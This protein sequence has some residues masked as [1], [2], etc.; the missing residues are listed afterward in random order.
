MYLEGI[1][2]HVLIA[3]TLILCFPQLR[4][5]PFPNKE[6]PKRTVKSS[7]YSPGLLEKQEVRSREEFFAI[8]PGWRSYI[9]LTGIKLYWTWSF[10]MPSN[11]S[12]AEE[13]LVLCFCE[14]NE[15]KPTQWPHQMQLWSFLL[16]AVSCQALS[17][18][19]LLAQTTHAALKQPG[20]VLPPSPPQWGWAL[21]L[22][23]PGAQAEEWKKCHCREKSVFL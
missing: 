7:Y 21:P 14:L 22:T 6:F 12:L 23:W 2:L 16:S 17:E 1:L 15:L 11:T 9:V 8:K 18:C 13:L 20:Y 19:M 5:A 4:S 3:H 10:L